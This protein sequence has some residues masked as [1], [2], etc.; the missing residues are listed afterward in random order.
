MPQPK[1]ADELVDEIYSSEQFDDFSEV[2]DPSDLSAAPEFSPLPSGWY[3]GE[4][5]SVETR[6]SQSGNPMLAW[7]FSLSLEDDDGR[8][9]T[10]KV[11]DYT[12][13]KVNG[14]RNEVG[15]RKIHSYVA[16][17]LG[18]RGLSTWRPIDLIELMSGLP[19]RIRLSRRKNTDG[20][21]QNE[22]KAIEQAQ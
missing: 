8:A 13:L 9:T 21:W 4:I 2:Y 15:Y 3:D 20:R 12:V 6:Y 1:N 10:R 19:C 7:T 22:V 5:E 14:K 11:W 16:A 17:L 18:D